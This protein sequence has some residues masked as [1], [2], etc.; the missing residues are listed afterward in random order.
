MLLQIWGNV[1]Q[2]CLCVWCRWHLLTKQEQNSH[3]LF[4]WIICPGLWTSVLILL[5]L[6]LAWNLSVMRCYGF[7]SKI[8]LDEWC[9]PSMVKV[10]SLQQRRLF[11]SF[12]KLLSCGVNQITLPNGKHI[13]ETAGI[14]LQ[15]SQ[16]PQCG[17]SGFT[18]GQQRSRG[19]GVFRFSSDSEVLLKTKNHMIGCLIFPIEGVSR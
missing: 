11:I 5:H 6:W 14:E 2:Q 19:S 16:L 10:I 8:Y 3:R 17:E 13:P 7:D 18:I 1:Q 15:S 9:S 4:T 12:L